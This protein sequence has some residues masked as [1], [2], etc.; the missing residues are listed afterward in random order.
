MLMKRESGKKKMKDGEKEKF[1]E[2][3]RLLREKQ[4]YLEM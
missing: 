1:L 2:E 4:Y 3:E